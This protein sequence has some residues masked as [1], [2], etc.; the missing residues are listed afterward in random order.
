V[1]LGP[2]IAADLNDFALEALQV[3]YV[4]VTILP[5]PH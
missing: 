3:Y 4:L 5:I 1:G 2:S